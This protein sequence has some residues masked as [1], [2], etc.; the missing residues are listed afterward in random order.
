MLRHSSEGASGVAWLLVASLWI[1]RL[2]ALLS[3]RVCLLKTISFSQLSFAESLISQAT[4]VYVHL[5]CQSKYPEISIWDLDWF[6]WI[7]RRSIL[8]VEC[9]NSGCVVTTSKR[10]KSRAPVGL[11]DTFARIPKSSE[12]SARSSGGKAWNTH[13][14]HLRVHCP[15]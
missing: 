4:K 11:F 12:I 2:V 15:K 14:A 5:L 3:Y 13:L 7:L 10:R 6:L 9:A 1:Y 8:S